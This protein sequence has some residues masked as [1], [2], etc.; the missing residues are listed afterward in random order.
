MEIVKI[1]EILIRCLNLVYIFG[2]SIYNLIVSV[3][4]SYRLGTSVLDIFRI[5]NKNNLFNIKDYVLYGVKN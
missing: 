2:F 4:Y 3:L 1:V 5:L